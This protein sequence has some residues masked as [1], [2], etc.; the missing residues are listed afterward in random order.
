M[1][2]DQG[3]FVAGYDF[4]KQDLFNLVGAGLTG[5]SIYGVT[6]IQ[7]SSQPDKQTQSAYLAA[8]YLVVS[9]VDVYA[10]A[11]FTHDYTHN[12]KAFDFS[13]TLATD[14]TRTNSDQYN[15]SAG[16]RAA[17]ARD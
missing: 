11:L 17:L 5:T 4:S 1:K 13:G 8:H 9:S 6:P 3:G 14:D 16:L 12:P 10:D 7:Y 15:V 2:T